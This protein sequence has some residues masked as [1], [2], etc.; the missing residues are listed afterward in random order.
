[1]QEVDPALI[2][3][4]S[5]CCAKCADNTCDGALEESSRVKCKKYSAWKKLSSEARTKLFAEALA[6]EF[7][8]LEEIVYE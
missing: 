7:I 2:M 3:F 5:A 4:I 6:D 8:N 1:M